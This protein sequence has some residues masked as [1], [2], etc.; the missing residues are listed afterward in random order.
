M[1]Y[2]YGNRNHSALKNLDYMIDRINFEEV[3][4]S[5]FLKDK[6]ECSP[7]HME[8]M[9]TLESKLGTVLMRTTMDNLE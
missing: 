1:K 3:D 4:K 6:N 2:L 9:S 8:C 7:M 5:H